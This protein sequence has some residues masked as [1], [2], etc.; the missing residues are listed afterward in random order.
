ML[1]QVCTY[2]TI[3]VVANDALH[4]IDHVA[5]FVCYETNNGSRL[6]AEN[7]WR[8]SHD[9]IL[10]RACVQ[11]MRLTKA[12]LKGFNFA[13]VVMIDQRLLKSLLVKTQ[14][15]YV[16]QEPCI[17]LVIPVLSLRLHRNRPK[18]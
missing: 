13:V 6:A 12:N 2:L 14:F 4:L 3:D 8:E 1:C 18:Q 17:D 5:D 16:W 10:L 9:D 15:D 7:L 11:V